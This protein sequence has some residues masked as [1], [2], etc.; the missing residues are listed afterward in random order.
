M[1]ALI[2]DMYSLEYCN[3]NHKI[4]RVRLEQIVVMYE[5]YNFNCNHGS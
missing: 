2:F 1:Y 3:N 4:L 5:I